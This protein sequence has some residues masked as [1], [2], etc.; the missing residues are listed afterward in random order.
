MADNSGRL[1]GLCDELSSFLTKINLYC[2][3]GLTDTHDLAVFLELYNGNEWT[4][5]TG[6]GMCDAYLC[7]VL[8]MTIPYLY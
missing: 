5:C 4:R 1:L 6:M 2:G 8:S 3:K 7:S